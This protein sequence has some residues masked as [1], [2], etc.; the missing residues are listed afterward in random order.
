VLCHSC[1][2]R[3]Q[4][5]MA[6]VMLMFHKLHAAPKSCNNASAGLHHCLMSKGIEVVHS[7]STVC[8]AHLM[9]LVVP[10]L[11]QL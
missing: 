1:S 7:R 10:S 5:G 2:P 6:A 9:V 8:Y 4:C 3:Y 11:G